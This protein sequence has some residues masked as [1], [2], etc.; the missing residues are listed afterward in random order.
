MLL[1]DTLALGAYQTNC[2]LVRA[3]GSTGCCV[4]DPGDQPETVF[5]ALKARNLTVDAVLLTHGHFDHVGAVEALA[6]ETGCPVWISRADWDLP[7]SPLT[8]RFYPLAGRQLPGL[9]FCREDTP[10]TA[11]GTVFTVRL[12]RYGEGGEER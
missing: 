5:R 3:E 1:V 6:D 10:I 2:Y 4:L 12:P 11:G 9:R 8:A 7:S